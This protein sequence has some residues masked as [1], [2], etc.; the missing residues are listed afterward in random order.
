MQ[1]PP[2]PGESA[3]K[4]QVQGAAGRLTLRPTPPAL[5]S[6]LDT[7]CPPHTWRSL[8]AGTTHGRCPIT[9]LGDSAMKIQKSVQS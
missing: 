2:S 9:L 5:A 3:G 1:Q 4:C 6:Y 8:K 7:L